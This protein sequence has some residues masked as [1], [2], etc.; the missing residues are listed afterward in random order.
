M[1]HFVF[2]GAKKKTLGA[3]QITC[4]PRCVYEHRRTRKVYMRP[5]LLGDGL[6]GGPPHLV[7]EAL[8]VG[9]LALVGQ[10]KNGDLLLQE[11]GE[12]LLH[13]VLQLWEKEM[14]RFATKDPTLLLLPFFFYQK[15]EIGKQPCKVMM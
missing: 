1:N 6:S 7:V 10:D 9:T 11:S 4:G 5:P 15:R 12:D 3:A 2:S 8:R 13:G 14:K